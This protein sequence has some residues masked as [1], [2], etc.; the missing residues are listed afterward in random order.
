[1][2]EGGRG[3]SGVCMLSGG[4][5]RLR[6]TEGRSGPRPRAAGGGSLEGGRGVPGGHMPT[7]AALCACS[8]ADLSFNREEGEERNEKK[9][10]QGVIRKFQCKKDGEVGGL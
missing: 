7:A 9:S 8:R 6:T 1:M 3:A 5:A 10:C 2:P 4:C